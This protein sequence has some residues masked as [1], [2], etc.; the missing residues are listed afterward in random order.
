MQ[1]PFSS[2]K[3]TPL[4]TFPLLEY[5]GMTLGIS[6]M[7]PYASNETSVGFGETTRKGTL[8]RLFSVRRRLG[9]SRRPPG[10]SSGSSELPAASL[11]L[12]SVAAR[13]MARMSAVG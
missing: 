6:V 5:R 12:S 4:R 3:V 1:T 10:D 8:G 11:D 7:S 2:T 13:R 9:G